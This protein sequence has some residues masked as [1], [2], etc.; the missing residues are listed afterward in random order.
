LFCRTHKFLLALAVLTMIALAW[1]RTIRQEPRWN[2]KTQREWV[3]FG[4][5]S[6]KTFVNRGLSPLFRDIK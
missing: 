6:D 2:G 1:F 5:G 4:Y 3:Q